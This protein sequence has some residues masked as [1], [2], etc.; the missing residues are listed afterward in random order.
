VNVCVNVNVNTTDATTGATALLLN[1]CLCDTNTQHVN[2]TRNETLADGELRNSKEK[3]ESGEN[4]GG[5][6]PADMGGEPPDGR[7]KY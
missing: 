7:A 5:R 1:V 6:A 4:P 3:R 2:S